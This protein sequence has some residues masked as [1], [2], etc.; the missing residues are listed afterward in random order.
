[1]KI[2]VL[3]GTG[4]IGGAIVQVLQERNHEVVSLGRT[5]EA[6]KL[7]RSAGA[8]PVEGDLRDPTKWIDTCDNVDGVV[9]A[10]A[11]WEDQMGTIDRRAADAILLRLQSG[12]STKA[13][14]YT[15]GCWM[16]G[17]TGN[18][19]ATEDSAL[20]PLASF[21]WAIP[22]IRSVLTARNVR[23]MV[24][25]P[26]M[27]YERDGGVFAHIFEDAEK[28]GY[29][30]VVGGENVRW[31]MVHRMD[32]ARVYVL[33]L[34]RGERGD[35]YNAA[36]NHGVSI[37]K[38]TRAIA[39]RLGINAAPVVC[40]IKTAVA[41]MGSWAEGYAIDQQ[42]SGQKARSQLGWRPEYEDVFAEI[43]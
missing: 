16:Y 10:A 40:D 4:S 39:G 27:V 1:M 32:L 23:G 25:H 2:F 29:V 3:G 13:F 33:M 38:I 12:D 42:M 6:C 20:D 22:T 31:P 18:S 11:V 9:Q 14:V 26:A 15:G 5:P 24:I 34:E 36:T 21:A 28:L 8:I 37:G 30:R 7:L 35:V 41:E 19:V 17:E 43:S